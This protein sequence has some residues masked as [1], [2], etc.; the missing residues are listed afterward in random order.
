MEIARGQKEYSDNVREFTQ[1]REKD[2]ATMRKLISYAPAFSRMVQDWI[3]LIE[4][5]NSTP[6]SIPSSTRVTR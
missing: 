2:E 5:M 6:V 3:K 4:T 1:S